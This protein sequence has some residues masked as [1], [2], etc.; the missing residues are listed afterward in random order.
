MI[1]GCQSGLP[2]RGA[3]VIRRRLLGHSPAKADSWPD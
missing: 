1:A 2:H 3:V